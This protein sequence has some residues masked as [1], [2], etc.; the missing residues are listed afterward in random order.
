ML[1]RSVHVHV[2]CL[3]RC[4]GAKRSGLRYAYRILSSPI[5]FNNKND[6]NN[7]NELDNNNNKTTKTRSNKDN[8]MYIDMYNN[9]KRKKKKAITRQDE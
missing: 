1:L 4:F 7:E 8:G 6:E 9:N 5:S 3:E 2:L